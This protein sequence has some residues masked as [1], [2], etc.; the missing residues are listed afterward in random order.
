MW[1][2]LTSI[3]LIVFA[4]GCSINR[5]P[6][7]L[8]MAMMNQDATDIV[9][10]GAPAYLL[11]LDALILT[12]PEDEGYLLAGARLYGAYAG[13]FTADEEQA[14][15]LSDKALNYSKRALCARSKKTCGLLDL[16]TEQLEE[17]I[18]E[19]LHKKNIELIYTSATTLAGWIQSNSS[20]W[21]AIAQLNKVKSLLS[22]VEELDPSYDNGMLQVYLG[23]LETQL[24]P[25]VGGQPEIGRQHFEQAIRVSQGH[26][27]MAYVMFAKQYARLMF[28][29]DLHDEL[30][31]KALSANPN[32]HG[33]TLINRLAQQEAANLL[34][35]SA[36]YFE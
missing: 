33:L 10:T 2:I 21:N 4:S 6:G 19:D 25:S 5:L 12:Y 32:T 28:E 16:S 8:S 15:L 29:Q 31:N 1:K 24:P 17:A 27:L 20:D 26:N 18:A 13:T 30:L 34:A 35:S 14:L 22:W 7:N 9:A 23:V 11:L 3:F 36:D